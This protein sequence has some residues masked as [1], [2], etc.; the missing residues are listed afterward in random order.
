[1]SGKVIEFVDGEPRV[2]RMTWQESYGGTSMNKPPSTDTVRYVKWLENRISI[3]E[4]KLE[5]VI[6][7]YK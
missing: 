6:N 4:K 1:M 3:L 5:E 7:G 2:R